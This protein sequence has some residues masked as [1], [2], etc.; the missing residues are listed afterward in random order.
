MLDARGYGIGARTSQGA[1]GSPEA[2][3]NIM[4]NENFDYDDFELSTNSQSN[5]GGTATMTADPDQELDLETSSDEVGTALSML[6]REST[7][8]AQQAQ[9][10]AEEVSLSTY[11]EAVDGN[12]DEPEFDTLGARAHELWH[13][14]CGRNGA[15][16]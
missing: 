3:V 4:S 11:E 16:T 8:A 5:S 15:R 6:I 7:E 14:C 13:F 2:K 9:A 10:Q 12:Y 1:S